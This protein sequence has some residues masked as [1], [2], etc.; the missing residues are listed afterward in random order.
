MSSG[1]RQIILVRHAHAEWPA[2]RGADF[3]RPLTPQGLADATAAAAAIRDATHRPDVLLTSPAI[4]TM[5]TADVIATALGLPASA[6][7]PVD[8]LYNAGPAALETELRRALAV[9]GSVLLVAHN[10]GISELARQL[11]G[12]RSFV[13]F[14]P[15]QWLH[16][17]YNRD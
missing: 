10:P 5:Q 9:A 12:D 17:F 2:Y 8:T 6:I 14:K 15:A 3:D 11:T 4:R 13:A 7:T 16:L 1:Q